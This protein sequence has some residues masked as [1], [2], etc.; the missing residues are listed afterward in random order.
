MATLNSRESAVQRAS[1]LESVTELDL[2]LV[3]ALQV[4]PRAA[5]AELAGPLGATAS[6]LARRWARLS[7]A[8]LAWVAAVPGRDSSLGICSAFATIRCRPGAR[9]RVTAW[10]V[11]RPEVVTIETTL[12]STD[13]L[14][15]VFASDLRELG[16]VLTEEL[17]QVEGIVSTEAIL[18]TSVYFEGTRWRLRSLDATQVAAL[19]HE[20]SMPVPQPVGLDAVDHA[21]LD[22]L[23]RDGRLAWVELAHRA[24][25]ST[26]TVRRRITR[27]STAGVVAFRCDVAHSLAGRPIPVS[28]LGSAPASGLDSICRGLA[29]LPECRLVAAVTGRANIFATLW[30]R[31]PADAQRLEAAISE[32]VPA[33][34]L[35]DRIVGL[36]TEKRMGHLLGEEGRR[37]GVRPIS[38]W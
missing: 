7:G 37:V 21:L 2:A 30:V 5:W 8:G 38:P 11:E 17:D 18:I 20:R 12:G 16:R 14:C 9:D 19:A 34:S 36:R 29:A 28:L 33:M 23:V 32:R 1:V 27:L 6:T 10:L 13:L 26:A 31:N 15:D 25:V 3:H 22:E 4:R 24:G 35:R